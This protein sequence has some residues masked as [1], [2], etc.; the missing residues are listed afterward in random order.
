MLG[1]TKCRGSKDRQQLQQ[2]GGVV[3]DP[4]KLW[5]MIFCHPF[6]A[7]GFGVAQVAAVLGMKPSG[8]LP[9]RDGRA[10]TC[11][12]GICHMVMLRTQLRAAIEAVRAEHSP[13]ADSSCG[14]Y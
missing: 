10:P 3:T 2:S 4:A 7:Q 6:L 5:G 13:K 8:Q 9:G 11:C 12:E 14:G 1:C